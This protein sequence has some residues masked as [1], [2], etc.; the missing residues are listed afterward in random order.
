MN[1][2]STLWDQ[3]TEPLFDLLDAEQQRI[4][5]TLRQLDA[6]RAAIIK[7][8]ENALRDLLEQIAAQQPAAQQ[9]EDRRRR[10]QAELAAAAGCAPEELNLSRLCALLSPARR[11]ALRARQQ[12]LQRDVRRLRGEHRLTTL[13]LRD[14]ARI[15]QALLRC[16]LGDV[17]TATYDARGQSDWTV[18]TPVVSLRA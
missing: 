5:A 15:N 10:L 9:H 12:D 2:E 6:L 13:L 18:E 11:A 14:C 1:T 8:D 3:R 4:E 7:R 16:L 17:A